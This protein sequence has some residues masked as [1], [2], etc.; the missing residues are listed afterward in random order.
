[1]P[2]LTTKLK[3]ANA[4]LT[5][6]T[7]IVKNVLHVRL[8]DIGMLPLRFV[9]LVRIKQYLIIIQNFVR[10]VQL[11]HLSNLMEFVLSVLKE[12]TLVLQ[13]IYALNVLKVQ[14]IM[15]A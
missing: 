12:L 14:P 13:I 4:L 10:P 15:P 7:I 9:R 8:L 6:L 1:M 11:L 3:N 2:S 5:N